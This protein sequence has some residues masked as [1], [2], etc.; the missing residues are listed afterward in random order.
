[1]SKS[2]EVVWIQVWEEDV[3]FCWI[4]HEEVWGLVWTYGIRSWI[5]LVYGFGWWTT[6]S[7]K[8]K[9]QKRKRRKRKQEQTEQ[10]SNWTK[11]KTKLMKKEKNVMSSTDGW[12]TVGFYEVKVVGVRVMYV[13][14]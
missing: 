9:S 14:V 1:M 5:V 13:D 11:L 4:E 2:N 7:D 8:W 10:K 12:G 3:W 6:S